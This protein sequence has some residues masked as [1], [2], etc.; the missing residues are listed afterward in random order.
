MK[1]EKSQIRK[2]LIITVIIVIITAVAAIMAQAL[3]LPL[4]ANEIFL[5]Q[6]NQEITIIL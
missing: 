5:F 3:S 6:I 1:K 4:S 2:Y